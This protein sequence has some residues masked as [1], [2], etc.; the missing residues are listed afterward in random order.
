MTDQKQDGKGRKGQILRAFIREVMT[1]MGGVTTTDFDPTCDLC[2][3]EDWWSAN[4]FSEAERQ[5]FCGPGG[6]EC[7]GF[8]DEGE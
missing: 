3:D 4:G 5:A 8:G 2:N 6:L 1:R 7:P